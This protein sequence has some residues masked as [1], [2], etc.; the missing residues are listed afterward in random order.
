M[1]IPSDDAVTS[2]RN[3]SEQDIIK[4]L[5]IQI[6]QMFLVPA[7]VQGDYWEGENDLLLLLLLLYIFFWGGEGAIASVE[8]P[9]TSVE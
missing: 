3:L 1:G 4:L 9:Q 7:G 6:S 8:V 5:E 2:D